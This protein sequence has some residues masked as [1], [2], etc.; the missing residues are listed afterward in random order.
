M[1]KLQILQWNAQGLK[2]H[3]PFL[4]K[5]LEE[6][7]LHPDVIC[8]QETFLKPGKSFK[9]KGYTPKRKDRTHSSKGGVITLIKNTIT[10]TD[11]ICP[12][13]IELVGIECITKKGKLKIYN[14]YN[15]GV[16]I[17]ITKYETMFHRDTIICG[18]FNAHNP[19]CGGE[20]TDK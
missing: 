14:I 7:E 9:L 15:P 16:E 11:L 2:S 8:I 19:L 20:K 6:N 13:D 1:D 17:D 12:D 5:Y 4:T 18:D 10:Y 3:L